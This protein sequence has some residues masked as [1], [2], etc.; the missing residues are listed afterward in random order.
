MI[1]FLSNIV[2]VMGPRYSHY[3]HRCVLMADT[4]GTDPF[5]MPDVLGEPQHV[6]CLHTHQCAVGVHQGG[7][8]VSLVF[9]SNGA[10]HF[11]V[12]GP[13]VALAHRLC[14]TAKEGT[15]LVSDVVK[16]T[17]ERYAPPGA[18][19]FGKMRKIVLRGRGTSNTCN[20]KATSIPL[21]SALFA[22]L[23]IRYSRLRK[24]FD[25]SDERAALRN[26]SRSSE[27]ASSRSELESN[28]GSNN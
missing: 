19:S 24:Y 16:E 11:D 8:T 27:S 5:T 23:G 9:F 10:P 12:L 4:F 15:I 28:R 2:Q 14:Q 3:P 13:P 20:V 18:I 25:E 1:Q 6:G 26:D 21:P 17:L 7:V 22:S